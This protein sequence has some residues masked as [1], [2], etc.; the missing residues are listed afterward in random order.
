M[1]SRTTLL[2]LRLENHEISL[3][4]QVHRA[5]IIWKTFFRGCFVYL[6]DYKRYGQLLSRISFLLKTRVEKKFYFDKKKK[7]LAFK[8]ISIRFKF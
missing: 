7:Y 8:R 1:S 2:S 5:H 3:K 4:L 6:V